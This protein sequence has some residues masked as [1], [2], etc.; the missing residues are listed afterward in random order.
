MIR[1]PPL[2]ERKGDIPLVT[3]YFLNIFRQENGYPNLSI[4]PTAM[5]KMRKYEWPGNVRELRNAIER[6][7]VM[8]NG[9][10]VLPEDLPIG[11]GKAGYAGVQVGMSLKEAEDNF[12]REFISKNLEQ[13]QGNRS[14]AAKILKIQRTYLSRLISKYDL[15]G[16]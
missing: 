12:K 16:L 3:E 14:Q 13:T 5:E 10:Q 2:R 7:V 6:A 4:S 9:Q 15:Q 11:D 1:M 8:G